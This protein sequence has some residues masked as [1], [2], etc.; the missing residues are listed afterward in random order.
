MPSKDLGRCLTKMLQSPDAVVDM[1]GFTYANDSNFN[2]V[3]DLL[4]KAEKTGVWESTNGPQSIMKFRKCEGAN[5]MIGFGPGFFNADG[6]F[7]KRGP[8]GRARQTSQ[9]KGKW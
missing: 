1:V 6:C 4:K 9:V 2:F 5:F 3:F 8:F 7:D